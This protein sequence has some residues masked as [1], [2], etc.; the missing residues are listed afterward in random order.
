MS[1]G[2]GPSAPPYD[3][4]RPRRSGVEIV[5]KASRP[6]ATS[7]RVTRG[8]D[9]TE[10][11]ALFDAV[12]ERTAYGTRTTFRAAQDRDDVLERVDEATDDFWRRTCDAGIREL[13]RR[14]VVFQCAD[15][16][17]LGVP[18]PEHPSRWGAR[19]HHAARVGLIEP[20]GAEPSRRVTV[21][22]SLVRTWRGVR[23]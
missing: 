23:R 18:E 14:G 15:L 11:G 12:L 21:R 2:V 1:A 4:R 17:E 6:D 19:L 7:T 20:V 5:E 16:L 9:K 8:A 3:E 10:P 13:A 22:A